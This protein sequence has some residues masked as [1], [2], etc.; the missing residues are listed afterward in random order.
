M[1]Q[2]QL[3]CWTPV[4]FFNLPTYDTYYSTYCYYL[5]KKSCTMYVNQLP[6]T[7]I[8]TPLLSNQGESSTLVS[9]LVSSVLS[10]LNLSFETTHVLIDVFDFKNHFFR[11]SSNLL[12]AAQR[13]RL[14]VRAL[15]GLSYFASCFQSLITN[16]PASLLIS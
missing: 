15:L 3:F 5:F 10:S 6:C 14:T 13:W 9:G 4:S 11:K 7:T 1:Y 2:F 8:Q 12:P 16:H